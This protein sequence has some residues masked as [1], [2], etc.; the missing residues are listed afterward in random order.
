M[1]ERGEIDKKKER[2]SKKNKEI[3]LEKKKKA[4]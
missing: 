1:K 2:I 3:E 4:I